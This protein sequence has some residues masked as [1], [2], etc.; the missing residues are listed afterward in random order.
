M[1]STAEGGGGWALDDIV[2]VWPE[3]REEVLY[4]V[5]LFLFWFD[6]NI[7]TDRTVRDEDQMRFRV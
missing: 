5:V 4:G 7:C 6:W 2:F 1:V 3:S